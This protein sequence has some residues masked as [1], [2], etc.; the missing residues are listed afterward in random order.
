MHFWNISTNL[1]LRLCGASI[2]N[3]QPISNIPHIVLNPLIPNDNSRDDS[4]P[5]PLWLFQ[6]RLL[7]SMKFITLILQRFLVDI[8]PL[9]SASTFGIPSSLGLFATLLNPRIICMLLFCEAK[10]RKLPLILGFYNNM[11]V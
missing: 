11:K 10:F 1:G 3:I 6:K 4:D 9:L 5:A 8:S 7:V 2:I